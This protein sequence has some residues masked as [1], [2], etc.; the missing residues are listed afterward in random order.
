MILPI[1][2]YGDPV[3]R[4]KARMVTDFSTMPE[5]MENMFE[6]MYNAKGVGLAAP[7]VGLSSRVFTW[8]DY[9][10]EEP[11]GESEPRSRVLHE[12]FMVNPTLEFLDKTLVEG[13]EGC[14]SIPEIYEEGVPRRRA[15]RVNYQNEHGI[16]KTLEVEDYNARIVQHEF[17]HLEA[18][19]FLDYLPSEVVATHRQDLVRMQREAK[20]FLK[21]LREQDKAAKKPRRT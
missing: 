7:Q 20:E 4:T 21:G 12:Y 14:L 6:T 17:D 2:L 13:L 15:L 1:R 18:K 8:V 9:A 5:L 3:L 10:D 16:H 11:E 19:L